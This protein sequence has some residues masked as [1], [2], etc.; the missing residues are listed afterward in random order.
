MAWKENCV[1]Y[2]LKNSRKA[3][4]GVLTTV[5]HV[6]EILLKTAFN[7]I[8][9]SIDLFEKIEWSFDID[10]IGQWQKKSLGSEQS[11]LTAQ[12]DLDQ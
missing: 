6:T 10:K 3:W 5:I 11:A 8:N 9:R 2:W 1:E 7:T 4:I 12:S